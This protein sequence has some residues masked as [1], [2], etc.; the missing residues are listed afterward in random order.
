[1]GGASACRVRAVPKR[2]QIWGL[3]V[4]HSRDWSVAEARCKNFKWV[5][6][7]CA[8]LA[9]ALAFG[10]MAAVAALWNPPGAKIVSPREAFRPEFQAVTSVDQAVALL[11][12]LSGKANPSKRDLVLA[13]DA[14]V[15]NRFVHGYSSYRYSDNWLAALAGLVW[16]KL[17]LPVMPAEILKHPT[18]ACSQQAIVFQAMLAKLGVDYASVGFTDHFAAAAKVDGEWVFYDA[19]RE[20]AP[21]HVPLRTVLSGQAID[22]LYPADRDIKWVQDARAGEVWVVGVNQNPAPQATLFHQVTGFMSRFGWALF[23]MLF[24]L[25]NSPA[26]KGRRHSPILFRGKHPDQPVGA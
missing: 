20:I 23:A 24:L 18:A 12:A 1:M 9:L 19:N 14:F 21:A 13:A 22:R 2:L 8:L 4:F 15:R 3:L 5:T 6:V 11:P 10:A 17:P 16:Y 7:R 26:V 25:L